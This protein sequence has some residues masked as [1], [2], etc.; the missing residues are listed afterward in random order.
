MMRI[1]SHSPSAAYQ[2]CVE[3]VL[4]QAPFLIDRW[5]NRL[6][7]ALQQRIVTASELTQ[8]QQAQQAI[9]LLG[10]HR[11]TIE[12]DFPGEL[13]QA[14]DSGSAPAAGLG[15]VRTGR[16]L[17]SVSFDDLE[18]MGEHQVTQTVENARLQQ[19][20]RLACEA[21][22]SAFSARLSTAQGFLVVK[23]GSNPLS[24]EVLGH[25]LIR[26]VQALPVPEAVRACWML[27]GAQLLGEEL[28][29]LYVLLDR[30]LA[31]Q[32][33][34]P[35]AYGIVASPQNKPARSHDS[36]GHGREE[37]KGQF[38]FYASRYPG[39]EDSETPEPLT[40]ELPV[41]KDAKQ[42]LTLDHLHHL[43]V[44]DY[45]DANG[46]LTPFLDSL[47][48]DMVH[49]DFSHTLPSALDALSE[50]EASGL[51]ASNLPL[52]PIEPPQP[53]AQMRLQL[54]AQAKSLGQS[55]AIEVVSLMIKQMAQDERLLLP[56]RQMIADAEPAFLRLAV[57]DPRF[58]SDKR[59]P[60]RRLLDSITS[61]SLAY[62]SESAPGF[63]EFMNQLNELA[64]L[65]TQEHAGNAEH[66]A[67]LLQDFERRQAAG[68]PQGRQLQRQAVQALVRA[69]QRNLL[70]AQI[71]A[72]IRLR[73]DFPV[74]S[75]TIAAF[76]TGPW[77]QVMAQER[78]QGEHVGLG[79][80]QA[81]FG[82]T[83]DDVLWSLE[84]AQATRHRKRLAAL[85]PAMLQSLREG[86]LSIDYPL[87]KSRDFF[88]ELM[89]IHQRGLK[90]RPGSADAP[91]SKHE[92]EQMFVTN[93]NDAPEMAQLWLAPTE[94]QQSGF[95]DDW[96]DSAVI[97][98]LMQDEA[99]AEAEVKSQNQPP[100]RDIS[101]TLQ[102]G[103]WVEL[104]VDMRW[105]RAQLTWVSPHHTLFMF[106]SEG[107]R[108]HSMTARILQHLL[109]IE[110]VKIISQ[111]GVLDGAL[112][113]VARTALHNSVQSD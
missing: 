90:A 57:T 100:A 80:T 35:A 20:V 74:A 85:I 93:D 31:S 66:F 3:E 103:D 61:A 24:P 75:R 87:E 21:G 76:L 88:D 63:A 14:I 83:L 70:A 45:D 56:V 33:I 106:T 109:K 8:K 71:A 10:K 55:L 27:D 16:S 9:E 98:S 91:A 49:P 54:K 23:A 41:P 84:A 48:D 107:G 12:L 94:A 101:P 17:S 108:K 62:A 105:L 43:L 42:L 92:L 32:G 81:A 36:P 22:L 96:E 67:R 28:Q 46:G 95:L 19:I 1:F 59:H 13:K 15:A 38:G 102:L 110:L 44:G 7:E 53:V 89:A 4:R 72:E 77:A 73:P 47:P 79:V 25:V 82:V 5:C 34:A 58:F 50:L 69:E 65:L 40:D 39:F 111:Q 64:A 30:F 86:L 104:M 18:L 2:A 113:G 78:L 51:N 26:L 60:A 112:D 68:S 6:Q 52:T 11:L 37:A 99:E 97:S 29:A